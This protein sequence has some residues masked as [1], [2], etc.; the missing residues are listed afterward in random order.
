[1]VPA[2]DNNPM[3]K[4]NISIFCKALSDSGLVVGSDIS[5]G[6]AEGGSWTI[7]AD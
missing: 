7:S 1:M 5:S 2:K 6:S 4:S 3:P